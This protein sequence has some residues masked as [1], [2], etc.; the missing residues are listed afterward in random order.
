MKHRTLQ[1]GGLNRELKFISK[2]NFYKFA[3]FYA[4]LM[5]EKAAKPS[6]PVHLLGTVSLTCYMYF[7]MLRQC[8]V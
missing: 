7:L 2:E 3:E 1:P 5:R 6:K 4:N 8:Y